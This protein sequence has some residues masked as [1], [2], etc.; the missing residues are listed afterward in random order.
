MVVLCSVLALCLPAVAGWRYLCVCE[1]I[2]GIRVEFV[3]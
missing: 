3:I 1:N 2:P